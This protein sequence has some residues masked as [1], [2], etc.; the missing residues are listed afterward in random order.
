MTSPPF[1]VTRL[2]RITTL[3]VSLRNL[4]L[5][6]PKRQFAPPGWKQKISSLL[7]ALLPAARQVVCQG[8]PQLVRLE[9]VVDL[10]RDAEG[11]VGLG[12]APVSE[13][14]AVVGGAIDVSG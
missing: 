7:P 8:V 13:G 6:S 10:A 3:V 5:P 4:T 11:G 1:R 2:R 12:P 14:Q 9:L